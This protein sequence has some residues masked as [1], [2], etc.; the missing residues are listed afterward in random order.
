MERF[1]T[2]HHTV[3]TS[4]TPF[5]Q[6]VATARRA[7]ICGMALLVTVSATGCHTWELEVLRPGQATQWTEPVRVVLTTG[8]EREFAAAR[9]SRDTLFGTPERGSTDSTAAIPI[10]DVL[11]VQ[12]REFS[13]D[14]TMSAW[15][16]LSLVPAVVLLAAYFI[17]LSRS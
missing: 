13:E 10:R 6:A 11:R 12:R 4:E 7:T 2:A 15:A 1:V 3:T 14:R 17:A 5:D 8:E 16:R 9:V